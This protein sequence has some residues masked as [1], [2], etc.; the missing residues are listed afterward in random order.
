MFPGGGVWQEAISAHAWNEGLPGTQEK[1]FLIK[2]LPL[3]VD[4]F[5]LSAASG[6]SMCL[7]SSRDNHYTA[8]PT[9]SSLS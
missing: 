4:E 8:S 2:H 6:E 7:L 5:F 1:F 9:S 3:Q